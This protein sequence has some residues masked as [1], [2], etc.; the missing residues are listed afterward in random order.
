M[1][2]PRTVGQVGVKYQNSKQ[3][4]TPELARSSGVLNVHLEPCSAYILLQALLT[5]VEPSLT[6]SSNRLS[7]FIYTATSRVKPALKAR[8]V[9]FD[10]RAPLFVHSGAATPFGT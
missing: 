4:L 9:A 2:N 3:Q 8:V 5:T 10:D 7:L 1:S 6:L